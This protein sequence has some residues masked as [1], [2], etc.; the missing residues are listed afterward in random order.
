MKTT[1]EKALFLII[2][3]LALGTAAIWNAK[4][5]QEDRFSDNLQTQKDSISFYKT[6]NGQIVAEK[7]YLE[8][9]NKEIKDQLWIKDDSLKDILDKYR[10]VKGTTIIK[11]VTKFDTIY[12][13][14]QPENEQGKKP[15][16]SQNKYYAIRGFVSDDLLA[17]DTLTIPNTQRAVWGQEKGFWKRE[18]TFSV[19]NSNPHI[20]TTDLA[21]QIV[22]ERI[23]RFGLGVFGGVDITGNPT[24]GA[25]LTWD[26][27]QF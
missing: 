26:L 27:I 3:A 21:T 1:I 11:T 7:K 22:T 13:K 24:W 25:G 14:L 9:T 18:Y 20:K 19:S 2:I 10:T 15:F 5:V 4:E 17:I 23:K 6:K 16:F 8:V 12:I